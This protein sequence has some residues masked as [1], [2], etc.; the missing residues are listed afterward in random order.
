M[1]KTI[2]KKGSYHDSVVLMLLTNQISSIEG[3]KKVSIMMATPANKDIYRQSGLST[4]ELE[5]ASA[6][7]MVVVADVDD[8]GLL[9]V[10]MEEVE[11]FFKKQSTSESDKKGAEAVRSWDKALGKLADANLAVIS[12]PGAYAALEADRALDEGMNVFMFSD[13]VTL[14]DEIKLKKLRY[15][16]HPGR[17]H[18]VYQSRGSGTHRHHRSVRHRHPGTDHHHRP[19]GRGR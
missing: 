9:D 7:D 16:N 19:S 6:N 11:A 8:D 12:I 18:C 15:R 14:E 1:L 17:A 2:V 4:S 10:I 5:E 13:N 3:V